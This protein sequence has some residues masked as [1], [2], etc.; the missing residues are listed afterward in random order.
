MKQVVS[1]FC[2]AL[3]MHTMAQNPLDP[4]A[5]VTRNSGERTLLKALTA[6]VNPDSRRKL[7]LK[8]VNAFSQK[9]A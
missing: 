2:C 8:K 6:I 3:C 1:A 7:P 9:A 5:P 4:S